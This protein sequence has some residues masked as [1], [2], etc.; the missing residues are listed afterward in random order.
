MAEPR[1]ESKAVKDLCVCVCVCARLVASVVSH[2]FWPHGLQPT[3]LLRPWDSPGKNTGVGCCA[4]LQGIFPPHGW[5]TSLHWRQILYCWAIREAP[6]DLYGIYT[7][8]QNFWVF[9]NSGCYEIFVLY[10]FVWVERRHGQGL[11]ICQLGSGG[12]GGV[13]G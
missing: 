10:V 6:K 13:L 7:N 1:F 9:F 11:W 8:L 4:L 5:N 3:R 2:S 12:A